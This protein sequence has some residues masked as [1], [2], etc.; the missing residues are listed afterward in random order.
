MTDLK[1][2]LLIVEDDELIAQ[3]YLASLASAPF[4]VE[5]VKDGESGWNAMQKSTPDLVIL[6]FMMPKLNGIE[7]LTKMRQ[8]PKLK[9]V[10]TVVMSSLMDEA[11][12]QRA[13]DAGATEY[14]VKNEVNMVDFQTK[15][16][17]LLA[18]APSS[19]PASV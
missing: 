15:I 6:D 19:P 2:R 10:P 17:S 13:L 1:K 14:W 12:K 8:D 5:L 4:T 7:V 9:P 18:R 3:M 16:N 11:D